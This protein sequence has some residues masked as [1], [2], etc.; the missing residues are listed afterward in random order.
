MKSA[1]APG[2][3]RLAVEPARSRFFLVSS[4]L[5]LAI[6]FGGFTATFYAR[7]SIWPAE[8]ILA[9]HGPVLPAHL[10]VHGVLLTA[11]FVLAFVQTCLVATGRT[12][13]HRMLGV[14]GVVVAAGIVP[15][16]VLTTVLRDAPI[17]DQNPWRAFGQLLTMTTFSICVVSAV[18][19]RRRP[20]DHKR[21]M[22]FASLSLIAPA[23]D[24]LIA[25]VAYVTGWFPPDRGPVWAGY[26][27]IGLL[28]IVVARDLISEKRLHRGTLWGLS[29]IVI[30]LGSTTGLIWSGGWAAFVRLFA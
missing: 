1:P 21:L 28:L 29:A 10:Y 17:I 12:D 3:S 2:P 15:S 9:R 22:W 7:P 8:V 30:A 13:V 6:V 18:Y 11:W 16:S 4:A 19:L 24:R 26:S 5:F 27:M 14:A 25:T 23:I 20:A